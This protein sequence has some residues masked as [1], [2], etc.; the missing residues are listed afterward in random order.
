MLKMALVGWLRN[1]C[2]PLSSRVT[3][4][5]ASRIKGA[6]AMVIDVLFFDYF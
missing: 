2:P 4:W 5:V 1:I 3:K 6:R